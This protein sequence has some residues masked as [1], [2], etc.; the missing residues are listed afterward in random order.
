MVAFLSYHLDSKANPAHWQLIFALSSA[1]LKKP[2]WDIFFVQI[3]V[4]Y[5]PRRYE[6][7]YQILVRIFCHIIGS[8][9]HCA[10]HFWA[11]IH[12]GF[13]RRSRSILDHRNNSGSIDQNKHTYKQT[14]NASMKPP[15]PWT[16][17]YFEKLL[18]QHMYTTT[19]DNQFE[20]YLADK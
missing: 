20:T 13:A 14:N 7:C 15:Q 17:M 3:F 16:P 19:G 18:S 10:S 5:I 1:A 8:D 11:S 6:N 2:P 9:S 4:I 12:V